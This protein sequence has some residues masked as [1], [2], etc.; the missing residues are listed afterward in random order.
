MLSYLCNIFIQGEAI[1]TYTANEKLLDMYYEIFQEHISPQDLQI[2]HYTSPNALFNILN[3]KTFWFSNINFLNDETERKYIYI[4]IQ[5]YMNNNKN[6]F[7]EL[8]YNE[9]S[10]ICSEMTS[11]AESIC[12]AS[13]MFNLNNKYVASFSLDDD[14]LN[15]WNYYTKN[16]NALGYNVEIDINKILNGSHT[17]Y[18]RFFGGKVIY[19]KQEQLNLIEKIILDYY[20]DYIN[21]T[22]DEHK[23]HRSFLLSE[24]TNIIQAYGIFFKYPYFAA[25]KEYRFVLETEQK[26]NYREFNGLFIPYIDYKFLKDCIK[27]ITIS[28]TQKQSITKN[29]I[30]KI[31]KEFEYENVQVKISKIPLRY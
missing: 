22:N 28:P 31:L 20:S 23:V 17:K 24:F 8:F 27:S 2:F 11:D 13:T 5:E 4:L 10:E 19:E 6:N 30:E 18:Y 12:K 9:I 7:S 14:N 15:L 21:W 29:S 1:V 3:S 26:C 16:P 25:E